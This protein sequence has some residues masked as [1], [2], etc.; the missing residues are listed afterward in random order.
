MHQEEGQEA[1]RSTPAPLA[2]AARLIRQG[3]RR[4]R[5]G[6]E[7]YWKVIQYVFIGLAFLLI[8]VSLYANW[9]ELSAHDWQLNLFWFLLSLFLVSAVVL[10][11]PVWW[12]LSLR[13]LGDR[14]AWGQGVRIWSIAQL[15]KYL[16]GGIWNYAS[17][18][19]AC[20]R[21][22]LSKRHVGLSLAIETILRIQAAAVAFLLS[23]SLWPTHEWSSSTLLAV[24]AL[25]LLGCLVLYPPVL[26]KGMN[27][28]LRILRREPV[29]LR[30]L[31]Y[32]HILLLLVLHTLTVLG[33][34]GAFYL[35]V[36]SVYSVPLRAALPMTGMLAVSVIAG[37]LNPL[38]PHGLGTREGLLIL[39]LGSYLP[40]PVAI[41]V[42]L[43]SRMWLTLSEL[44][45]VLLVT[46][47]FRSSFVEDNGS[48]K[49]GF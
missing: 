48:P 38:T 22:G 39:L 30:A 28:A 27:G 6:L 49:S 23:L 2:S 33:S 45:S 36:R 7:T 5:G 12:T 35:M 40:A 3:Y 25:L 14:L 46:L 43:L 8:G 20:D 19:Y 42:S 16:P 47:V 32:R 21:A 26:Q 24:A 15:A 29:V 9:R 44:L 10:T 31:Q 11:L 37:F 1:A 34:G 17:R 41:V 13:F 18:L 4:L